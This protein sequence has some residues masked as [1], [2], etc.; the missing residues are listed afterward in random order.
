[1]LGYTYGVEVTGTPAQHV[2]PIRCMAAGLDGHIKANKDIWG[3]IAPEKDPLLQL[4]FPPLH[5]YA[6][7]WWYAS[8]RS[9]EN[10]AVLAPAQLAAA[11]RAAKRNY[12]NQEAARGPAMAALEALQ[13]AE[14][15]MPSHCLIKDRQG[16]TWSLTL[17]SPGFLN[18]SYKRDLLAVTQKRAEYN[19]KSWLPHM[20]AEKW[21][22]PWWEAMRAFHRS[23]R[24]S[25]LHKNLLMRAHTK[26]LLTN[27]TLQE[28][29]YDI[30]PD[31]SRCKCSD[32]AQHRAYACN[33][34]RQHSK[35]VL[36]TTT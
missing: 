15:E 29:G 23:Q 2:H 8:T 6:A 32:T 19:M 1:M 16:K 9:Q 17:H 33:T 35:H 24:H 3:A 22:E 12:H 26:T 20:I 18:R 27:S 11:W 21:T 30:N 14:W 36:L 7:E 10:G 5:R 34:L 31:C 13:W 28:W 25:P 4:V